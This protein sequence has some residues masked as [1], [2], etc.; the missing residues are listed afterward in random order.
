MSAQKSSGT[1]TDF[2]RDFLIGGVSAAVSKTAVAP[3]ERVKLLLQTQDANK[4]I[5]E[6]GAKKYNGIVDC[7]IRVNREEVPTFLI[8]SRDSALFGEATSLMFSDTSPLKPSTLPSRT[9]TKSGSAPSVCLP[10]PPFSRS[11]DR[12]VQVLPRKHDVRRCSWCHISPD[13]LPS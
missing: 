5:Q 2:A 4:K 10:F 3:I 9:P 11:Q 7:F 13:R 12:K 1:A 8:P 6:G